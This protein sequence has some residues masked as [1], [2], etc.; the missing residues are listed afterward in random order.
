MI[1]AIAT[2]TCLVVG[3]DEIC[4]MLLAELDTHE[5]EV[6]CAPDGRA[7][8]VKID[9][10][11]KEGKILDVLFVGASLLDHELERLVKQVR[12][13]DILGHCRIVAT[14]VKTP[15]TTKRMSEL[16]VPSCVG[17]EPDHIKMTAM[18]WASASRCS[19]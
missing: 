5:I 12:T 6:E 1:T 7:A 13:K 17:S 11:A 10:M 4:Q 14:G 18:Y 9:R 2:P 8:L 15:H 3:D 19:R 16:G